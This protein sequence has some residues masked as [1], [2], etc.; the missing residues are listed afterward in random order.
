MPLIR[1]SLLVLAALL[2]SSAMCLGQQGSPSTRPGA[3][4]GVPT[5]PVVHILSFTAEPTTIKPGQ[6]AKLSWVVVNASST[7][8]D[9]C[10]GVVA[11][12]GTR[13]V[14]PQ[15]TTTYTF[16][17]GG[18]IGS[19][20]KSV[21]I[22]V[23][24]TTPAPAN[25]NPGCVAEKD[26]PVPRLDGKPDLSGVYIGGFGSKP[27]DTPALK[28]GAK[29][30]KIIPDEN[31]LGQGVLCVPP[32]VPAA[33]MMPYP[34][35]IVQ[36]QGL[37]VILYEAYHLFRVIP[38]DGQPHPADLDP[39]WMGNSVGRWEGDTLVVDAIGFNDKTEI[40]GFNHTTAYHVVERYRRPSYDTLQYE[41]T[42]DDPNVFTAPWRYKFTMQLH[43]EWQIQEY[44][45]EENNRNYRELLQKK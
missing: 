29:H 31:D 42:I 15:V 1:K 28:P 34:I 27:I 11:T 44:V 2:C 35:Q 14:S 30:F 6:K 40:E 20:R 18:R 37:V 5:G 26:R 13:E 21:T 45:C 25:A 8:I 4:E 10:I 39:T 38:T 3:V 41:A 23:R 7:S 12:R 32:G 43:S 9:Q 33:T 22:T 24:G 36:K 19:D 16:S 17:A